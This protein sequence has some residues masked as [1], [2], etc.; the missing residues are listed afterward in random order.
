M[1]SLHLQERKKTQQNI[2]IVF[3]FCCTVGPVV[4]LPL[5][6]CTG[7]LFS[8]GGTD[9]EAAVEAQMLKRHRLDDLAADSAGH[10]T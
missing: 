10:E 7:S 1:K 9:T 6:M 4:W 3:F 2:V 5:W 8:L